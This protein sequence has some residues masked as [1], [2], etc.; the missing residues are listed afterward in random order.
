KKARKFTKEAYLSDVYMAGTMYADEALEGIG[1]GVGN[2]MSYGGF[3][4]DDLP[5][6]NSAKLFPAGIV[7]N[8]DL[9]KVYE[10]DQTKITEDVTHAW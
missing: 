6:Y 4:L 3:R 1:G 8:R 9:S 5:F 2:Y 10:I 7:K